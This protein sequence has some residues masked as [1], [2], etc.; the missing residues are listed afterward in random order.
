M[1]KIMC[2]LQILCFVK[3]SFQDTL[4]FIVL[5]DTFRLLICIYCCEIAGFSGGLM[6]SLRKSNIYFYFQNLGRP[7]PKAI[8]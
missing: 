7:V 5:Y 1:V 3:I 6:F 2:C 8:K 4:L